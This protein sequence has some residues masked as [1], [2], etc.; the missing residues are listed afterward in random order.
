MTKAAIHPSGNALMSPLV[1]IAIIVGVAPLV[2]LILFGLSIQL[3]GPLAETTKWSEL[4]SSGQE[5]VYAI[6]PKLEGERFLYYYSVGLYDYEAD[7]NII[8][9]HRVISYHTDEAGEMIVAASTYDEI[10]D[11]SATFGDGFLNDTEIWIHHEDPDYDFLLYFSE[12]NRFGQK[13][14]DF[15]TSKISQH[16]EPN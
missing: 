8:T 14:A 12:E 4:G 5:A 9:S 10:T 15:I 1:K 2:L 13:I 3:I 6:V 7:G 16:N 11:I